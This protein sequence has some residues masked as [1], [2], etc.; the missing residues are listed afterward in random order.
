MSRFCDIVPHTQIA[1]ISA[2]I[3][4]A[5]LGLGLGLAAHADFL[6]WS[7]SSSRVRGCLCALMKRMLL[8]LFSDLRF[9]VHQPCRYSST[10]VRPVNVDQTDYPS[11]FVG[12]VTVLLRAGRG[13]LWLYLLLP[14]R[15]A[16]NVGPF[17]FYGCCYKISLYLFT[18]ALI[19]SSLS[20]MMAMWHST[21]CWCAHL[22]HQR[23]VVISQSLSVT[24]MDWQSQ[25]QHVHTMEHITPGYERM[26]H[27]S[28]KNI[29]KQLA[30][31]S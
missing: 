29:L 17:I 15:A 20:T 5:G 18:S 1:S 27:Y 30:W 10:N 11:F 16:L 25:E 24:N 3:C 2:W 13:A 4:S 12:T 22:C 31:G 19:V 26:Q 6:R 21:P 7:L 8:D 28:L 9:F 14:S 23:R